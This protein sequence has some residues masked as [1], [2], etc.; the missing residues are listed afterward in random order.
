MTSSEP[1]DRR[2][3]AEPQG[4]VVRRHADHGRRLHL[5]LAGAEREPRLHRCRRPAL[6]RRRRRPATARSPP[7]SVRLRQAARRATRAA[8]ADRNAG[9]C[10]N[11]R[12]VTV[13]FKPSFA[14]WRSL[15]TNIVPAHIARTVGWNT[16]FT[17]PAQVISGSWFK[18]QSYNDEPVGRPDPQPEVLEH[19]GQAEQARL[20]VLLGRQP[21]GAGPPEQGDRHLQPLDC[22]PRPSCRRRTRCRT[23]R[24]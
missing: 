15:F 20:P 24:R 12:T 23:R 21:A 6:R 2:L 10:P 3:H 19:A 18:I 1:A 16:G 4:R 22:E 7:S 9:L 14:D 13:T 11:G 8:A 5:Q 17:G